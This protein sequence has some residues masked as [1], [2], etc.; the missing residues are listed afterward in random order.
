MN[1]CDEPLIIDGGALE[2]SVERHPFL[3]GNAA[4]D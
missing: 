2:I 4:G 1:L 3:T